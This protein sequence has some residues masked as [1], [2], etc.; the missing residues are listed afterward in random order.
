MAWFPG[1]HNI[2]LFYA[3]WMTGGNAR[4]VFSSAKTGLETVRCYVTNA[5]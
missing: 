3:P 5:G 2:R 4:F 1:P